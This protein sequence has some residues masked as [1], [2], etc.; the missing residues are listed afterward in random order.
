MI[1]NLKPKIIFFS[2]KNYYVKLEKFIISEFLNFM[3]VCI[4]LKI[5]YLKNVFTFIYVLF[6]K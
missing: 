3:Q 1:N 6:S 5:I 2:R 4:I